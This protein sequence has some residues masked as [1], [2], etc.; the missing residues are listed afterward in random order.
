MLK[1]DRIC[2]DFHICACEAYLLFREEPVFLTNVHVK[3]AIMLNSLLEQSPPKPHNS[4]IFQR[5]QR[6]RRQSRGGC[7]EIPLISSNVCTSHC[8]APF[9]GPRSAFTSSRPGFMQETAPALLY[10]QLVYKK[11][12]VRNNIY[13]EQMNVNVRNHWHCNVGPHRC[14]AMPCG[15]IAQ[16]CFFAA[17]FGII[18]NVDIIGRNHWSQ[19]ELPPQQFQNQSGVDSITCELSHLWEIRKPTSAMGDHCDCEPLLNNFAEMEVPYIKFPLY[20]PIPRAMSS[21][22]LSS[23]PPVM[24]SL[25]CVIRHLRFPPITAVTTAACIEAMYR[26]QTA[27]VSGS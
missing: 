16:H 10:T 14:S 24:D 4:F 11:V 5:P 9:T 12:E 13:V 8:N 2:R 22:D 19:F 1:V 27:T 17:P 25:N 21:I 15:G 23:L 26:W 6:I 7:I 20:L 3:Q 18:Y